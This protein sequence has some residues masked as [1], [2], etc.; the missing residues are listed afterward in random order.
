MY[1][2]IFIFLLLL[3]VNLPI[4]GQITLKIIVTN[5]NC[6]SGLVVMDFSDSGDNLIRGISEKIANKECIITVDSLKP[7]R[8]SFKYFHDENNN[9]KIDTYWIGAPKEGVG[10][11]NNAKGKFGPPQ[12]EDTIFELKNDTTIVCTAYYIKI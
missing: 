12:F 3:L 8:Y 5:L 9:K 7:G 6:N 10:F 4:K 2:I 11:S 1:K